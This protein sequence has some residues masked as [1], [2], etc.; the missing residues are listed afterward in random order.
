MVE[1]ISS[2]GTTTYQVNAL[3]QRVYKRNTLGEAFFHYDVNGHLIADE[4]AASGEMYLYPMDGL[5]IKTTEGYIAGRSPEQDWQIVGV[6]DLDGDG[7]ADI[8]WR[9]YRSGQNYLYP[10][11]GTTV[12]AT[13]GYLRSVLDLDWKVVGVGDFNGDGRADILWR[14]AGTGENYVYLMN[15][16]NIIGEGYLRTVA[17]QNWKIAGIR[18]FDGDG[19][20]DILWRSGAS[21]ENYIYLMNGLDIVGEGYIRTVADQNW[22]IAGVGDLDGDHKGDIVWRNTSTGENYVYFMDGLTIRPTEGFIRTVTDQRWKIV[23]IGDFDGDTKSDILWRHSTSGEDYIYPMDGVTIKATEGYI[24]QVSDLSWQVSG[25]GDL[26]GDGRADIYWRRGQGSGG[27]REF[28]YLGDIPVGVFSV[29]GGDVPYYVHVDHLNTPRL[30]AN[31]SGQTVWRWDQ[32]E[33][34]GIN[35]PD[36]NPSGLGAFEFPLRFPGQY[37]DKETNLHYNYFRDYDPSLGR[38]DESDPIGLR[39]GINTYAYADGRPLTKIDPSGLQGIGGGSRFTQP[40]QTACANYAQ[41]KINEWQQEIE[42]VKATL[43]P[44]EKRCY[45]MCFFVTRSPLGACPIDSFF[46]I[47]AYVPSCSRNYVGRGEGNG[48]WICEAGSIVGQ[49]RNMCCGE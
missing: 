38:Y 10:M 18:D 12:K 19:R 2:I 39:G 44:C 45:V 5:A 42:R 36:E 4:R 37:A 1:A 21:G 29:D 48:R 20:A 23:G 49:S 24:R 33:P 3:G 27:S 17:D 26:D 35:V 46:D 32:Q 40:Y 41:G 25:V 30:V 47:F 16:L 9:N 22:K 28:V 8:V 34:F 43:A 31:Q 15:G 13:E 7:R 6:G 14:H 11:D